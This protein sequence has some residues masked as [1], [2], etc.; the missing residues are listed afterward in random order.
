MS[1]RSR[2]R[3]RPRP[4]PSRA[5]STMDSDD[6]DDDDAVSVK[7]VARYDFIVL[8][9]AHL[10]D[11]TSSTNSRPRPRPVAKSK[12]IKPVEDD[13][14]YAMSC[15][16]YIISTSGRT[17]LY[18]IDI[19]SGDDAMSIK[20]SK[21]TKRYCIFSFFMFLS[22]SLCQT[23]AMSIDDEEWATTPPRRR[24]VHHFGAAQPVFYT[25]LTVVLLFQKLQF[26]LEPLLCKWNIYF[27]L[28]LLLTGPCLKQ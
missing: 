3:P 22:D 21:S 25:S 1:E 7:S 18:S 27:Y 8:L 4:V 20:S 6:D 26:P 14:A 19:S 24:L 16:F 28:L 23:S 15:H 11:L 2:S 12:S 9:T 10:A 5:K 13:D 17:F